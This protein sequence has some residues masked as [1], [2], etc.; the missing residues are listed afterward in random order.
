M[1]SP[2]TLVL[3]AD[4]ARARFFRVDRVRRGLDLVREATSERAR[5]K[6]SEIAT[7]RQG[8]AFNSS[9]L[10]QR[11]AMEPHTDP[12]RLE[13]ERFARTL[14]E[15]LQSEVTEVGIE[16]LILVAAPRTLGDLRAVLPAVVAER[17]AEEIDKDLV[18]LDQRRLEERLAPTLF[19]PA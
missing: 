1:K 15:I 10:G 8:R 9:G 12:Q 5:E 6:T 7:D 18:G 3:V 13:K 17:V 16:R 2:K 19:G 14:A 4:G 11:S